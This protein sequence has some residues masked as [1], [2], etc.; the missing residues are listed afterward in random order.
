MPYK[1]RHSIKTGKHTGKHDIDAKTL[2]YDALLEYD[3]Y[4]LPT[5]FPICRVKNIHFLSWQEHLR[6]NGRTINCDVT[7]HDG[8]VMCVERGE[9]KRFVIL[10][11]ETL[12]DAYKHWVIAKLL[13]Y[14]RSGEAEE[15]PG[16]YFP[17]DTS[18]EAIEFASHFTCPD[19]VLKKRGILSTEDIMKYCQIPFP[20]ALCKAKYLKNMRD[21]FAFTALELLIQNRFE[22]FRLYE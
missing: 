14:I 7:K 20:D 8:L 1:R 11:D 6:D 17:C 2:A 4:S 19:I 16:V 22:A 10:Y 21:N 18:P 15:S 9:N 12:T 13:Y 3:I 5:H